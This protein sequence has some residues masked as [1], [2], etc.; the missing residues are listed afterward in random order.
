[1]TPARHI[2][3]L[4]LLPAPSPPANPYAWRSADTVRSEVTDRL[5]LVS[6][7]R[8]LGRQVSQRAGRHMVVTTGPPPGYRNSPCGSK[9][10]PAYLR[11]FAGLVDS[12]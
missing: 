4:R 2:G 1:M 3:Q 5:G 9:P 11:L 6:V 8:R 10:T 12:R 7:G